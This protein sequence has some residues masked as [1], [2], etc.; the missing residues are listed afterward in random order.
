MLRPWAHYFGPQEKAGIAFAIDAQHSPMHPHDPSA[1]LLRPVKRP[2]AE[3]GP[4]IRQIL[5]SL[6]GHH[7]LG[8][9]KHDG[10]GRALRKPSD[11]GIVSCVVAGDKAFVG[12][13]VKKGK[14]GVCISGDENAAASPVVDVVRRDPAS[15]SRR[16]GVF[17]S[18]VVYIGLPPCG[19]QRKVELGRCGLDVD[20]VCNLDSVGGAGVPRNVSVGMKRKL[21]REESARSAQHLRVGE[22]AHPMI[23]TEYGD[24]DAQAMKRLTQLQPHDARPEHDHGLG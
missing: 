6:T 11:L 9:G 16:R 17:D 4:P 19:D 5:K 12:G 10:Y 8:I 20:R 21:V 14:I 3:F 1:T 18:V 22:G 23:L 7:D 15:I 24:P 2:D 13:L